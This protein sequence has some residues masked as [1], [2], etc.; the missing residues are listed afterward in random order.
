MEYASGGELFEYIVANTRIKEKEA[1]GF[2]QQ[3]LA[4]VEYLHKLNI[5]HRDL[6]PEN[7]LLD[8]KK[9][10]K[11]A[12]FGLSNTFKP[13]QLLKTACGSPCYAAPEM[14]E[15][16]R[17][18]GAEVDVWSCGIVMFALICGYLP[19]ED[20]NTSQLYKKI[21][22]GEF[23]MPKYISEEAKDLLSKI[24]NVNP[25]ERYTIDQIR[26]HPW[27]QMAHYEAPIGIMVGFDKIPIEENV[28]EQ[29]EQF[30]FN[31][32]QAKKYL[33]INK[34][35][36]ITTTYY[37]LLKRFQLEPILISKESSGA[38]K[39]PSRSATPVPKIPIEKIIQEGSK[40]ERSRTP[41]LSELRDI[42]SARK[43]EAQNGTTVIKKVENVETPKKI[44]IKGNETIKQQVKTA[45]SP[46]RNI[47]KAAEVVL[48]KID[49]KPT[50]A[51]K[52]STA[53]STH[54]RNATHIVTKNTEKV[55]VQHNSISPHPPRSPIFEKPVKIAQSNG[56][57]ITPREALKPYNGPFCINCTST[58]PTIEIIKQIIK[59][60][61]M[62]KA[63]YKQSGAYNFICIKSRFKFEI[64]LNYIE[65][66]TGLKLVRF[67]N[68]GTNYSSFQAICEEILE[69][70][71]LA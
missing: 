4:G 59:A 9:R 51:P 3:I 41:N 70:M 6:K 47:K 30:G 25:K 7:L 64:E 52:P 67:I 38:P 58:R 11:I 22:S 35:N 54:A 56:D 66:S 69:L 46:K 18:N 16:K 13:G 55:R 34:H 36:H 5:A 32:E 1:C 8:S 49:S 62:Q 63:T 28:L 53:K 43:F 12:D 37:L 33:E 44:K 29:L 60:L 45:E 31:S 14:I 50:E 42:D 15:G 2:F 40:T 61:E 20:P 17:Y 24:I 19:F 65:G 57:H 21:I 71:D 23:K 48:K 68:I 27:L 26:R 10:I 39:P